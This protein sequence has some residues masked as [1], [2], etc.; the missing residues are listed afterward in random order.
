MNEERGY[1]I[2]DPVDGV[3]TTS[4][5]FVMIPLIEN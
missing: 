4:K 2:Y 5:G 1:V 3:Y